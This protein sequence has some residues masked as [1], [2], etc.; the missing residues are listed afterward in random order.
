MRPLVLTQEGEVPELRDV[1]RDRVLV[2]S[3]RVLGHGVVDDLVDAVV[4]DFHHYDRSRGRDAAA[5]IARLNA[6]LASEGRRYLLIG[7]G[8][9]GSTD[10][11]LGI[12]VTWDQISGARVIVEAGFRDMRVTPSQ[13]SHFFQNLTSFQTGSSCTTRKSRGRGFARFTRGSRSSSK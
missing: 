13:G 11:W 6:R 2:A 7:V 12:P 8:R 3:P 1:E 4:V 9:W 10:P 5:E